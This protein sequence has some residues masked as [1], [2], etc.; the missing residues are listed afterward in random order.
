MKLFLVLCAALAALLATGCSDTSGGGQLNV[1]LDEWK[2]TLDK[3]SLPE[4]PI[5]FTIKNDGEKQHEFII[6]RTDIAPG[7]LPT[8]DD[9]SADV[10]A[11]DV[12]ELHTVEELDD[13]DETGRTYTLDAGKYVFIDNTVE[14][15]NGAKVSHYDQGMRVGFTITKEG[16]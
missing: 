12:D 13:G 11:P 15:E 10:N 5:E 16:E 1:T 8:N 6:L 3:T 9:G 4:G 2:I 14:E 7:E